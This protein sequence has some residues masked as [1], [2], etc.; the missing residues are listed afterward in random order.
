MFC[1]NCDGR[2]VCEA[3]P[4]QPWNEGECCGAPGATCPVCNPE[5]L[6]P[7]LPEGAKVI[8]A[9]DEPLRREVTDEGLRDLLAES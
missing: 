5:G 9:V 7:G 4:D 2:W 8:A 1:D 6:Y 3:H